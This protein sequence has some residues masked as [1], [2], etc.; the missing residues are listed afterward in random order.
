MSSHFHIFIHDLDS[1]SFI[2]SELQ[3]IAPPV[4]KTSPTTT[5]TIIMTPIDDGAFIPEKPVPLPTHPGSSITTGAAGACFLS[6]H[7]EPPA[8]R[9]NA[10]AHLWLSPI[11]RNVCLPR[12]N[13]PIRDP[14]GDCLRKVTCD[15]HYSEN[16]KEDMTYE[17]LPWAVT[18]P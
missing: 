14:G 12:I 9:T 10:S 15:I 5:T 13:I 6:T 4:E 18:L 7:G 3:L 8:V 1:N 16:L 11:D 17:T 2:I